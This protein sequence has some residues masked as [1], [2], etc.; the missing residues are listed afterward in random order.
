[1]IILPLSFACGFLFIQNIE[2]K[3]DVAYADETNITAPYIATINQVPRAVENLTYNGTAQALVTP[4]TSI[5]GVIKYSLDGGEWDS[6][7]PKATEAGTYVV[8]CKAVGDGMVYA[9][10]IEVSVEVSI[11][12]ATDNE[13]LYA[14]TNY[15]NGWTYGDTPSKPR[16]KVRY[17]ELV[18]EY[19]LMYGENAGVYSTEI[20]TNAGFY[21][22]RVSCP[23]TANYNGLDYRESS[24]FI[25][26]KIIDVPEIEVQDFMYDGS[27]KII[28]VPE[29]EYYYV[30]DD[31]NIISEAGE[32]SLV[33]RLT[34]RLN[35]K[36]N[37]SAGV[38]FNTLER[39]LHYDFSVAAK[40]PAAFV[41]LPTIDETL[42]YSGEEIPLLL[43]GGEATNG[44]AKYRLA[45]GEW[46]T[47]YSA[48]TAKNV[49]SYIV[50]YMVEADINSLEY[51]DSMIYSQ[52][53]VIS[54]VV[55]AKPILDEREFIF[56]G[57]EQ[58][59]NVDI[60]TGAELCEDSDMFTQ[61]NV[62]Y[63]LIK[64]KLCDTENY[65]WDDGTTDELA[66]NFVI[67][68]YEVTI[69]WTQDFVYNGETQ[70]VE[71]YYLDVEGSRV[72]LV[73]SVM[74]E[75][76]N[77]GDYQAT[78]SFANEET[79][80]I[81]PND[82]DTTITISKAMSQFGTQPRG[83]SAIYSD[84]MIDLVVAGTTD[85]GVM[86]YSIDNETWS[87]S[88]PQAS[89][90]GNY[91]V[92][93]KIVGDENHYDSEIIT[94]FSAISDMTFSVMPTAIVGLE[95]D[96]VSHLL[97]TPA[98][99]TET[100]SVVKYSIDGSNTWS[101]D[102]PTAMD[103]GKYYVLCAIFIDGTITTQLEV[104]VTI[105]KAEASVI[106]S[107]GEYYYTG[108]EQIINASFTDID[109]QIIS[110]DVFVDRPFIDAGEYL[111]RIHSNEITNYALLG[112]SKTVTILPVVAEFVVAPKAKNIRY[113]SD[114]VFDLIEK[115]E[116]ND[117]IVMYSLDGEVWSADVPTAS[118][119]GTY[120][121][122]VK[123]EPDSNHLAGEVVE[124]IT[125]IADVAF[126]VLPTAIDGLVYDG[127]AHTLITSAQCDA[128]YGEV[129]YSIDNGLNWTIYEPTAIDAGVY[130]VWVAIFNGEQK[131]LQVDVIATLSP[132]V[133]EIN[134]AKDDFTYNGTIQEI[135]IC[136]A[137][138][139]G[140]SIQLAT[141]ADSEFKDAGEYEITVDFKNGEINYCLPSTTSRVYTMKKAVAHFATLPASISAKY[142]AGETYE[143]VISGETQD[144]V[145]M[146]SL[147]GEEWSSEVPSSSIVGKYTVLAKVSG[148]NN[149]LDSEIIE[150]YSTIYNVTFSILPTAVENL[151]YNGNSQTL[152]TQAICSDDEFV[153]KYRLSMNEDWS[154]V[155]PT[156]INAGSYTVMCAA[157]NGDEVVEQEAVTVKIMPKVVTINW[158]ENN[159]VYNGNE[160]K[161]NANYT[162]VNG[163]KVDLSVRVNKV[164]KNVA[165]NYEA[166]VSFA[167]LTTNYTLP[168]VITRI[169]TIEPKE[170]EI[171]WSYN[172]YT[173][174]GEVQTIEANYLDVNQNLV[175]LSV[176][177]N[178]PFCVAGEYTATA[179]FKWAE[180][181]YCLPAEVTKQFNMKKYLVT[182]PNEDS[183]V[184]YYTGNSITYVI[185]ESAYYTVSGNVVQNVGRYNVVV[186]LTDKAN[187]AWSDQTS[188]NLI[189]RFEVIQTFR[190]MD[191]E[192]N[193][194]AVVAKYASV[195]SVSDNFKNVEPTVDVKEVIEI[196]NISEEAT[197]KVVMTKKA[198]WGENFELVLIEGNTMTLLPYTITTGENGEQVVN[199]E[200][201]KQGKLA[202][203]KTNQTA[204]EDN[205]SAKESNNAHVWIWIICFVVIAG[206]MI[207]A[208]LLYRRNQY[209]YNN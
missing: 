13:Y 68:P 70:N 133:V 122:L 39:D 121:V 204:Q 140:F 128:V 87:E 58:T 35:Y 205:A 56:N 138:I 23:A 106:W 148:D 183:T 191:K 33:I 49:G 134:W 77:A 154:E 43:T 42:V 90:K 28:E 41:T 20:P 27:T 65:I 168:N 82:T 14:Y 137:D 136:Y 161:I 24:F 157:V 202:V 32:Y 195:D 11:L 21:K 156:R 149:H 29:S 184:Y 194:E 50:E 38:V 198:E 16:I 147:D 180:T 112:D 64:I 124:L 125:T 118:E 86:V 66:F 10:S 129:R 30:V 207:L 169:Y 46:T 31:S 72:D 61:T 159:F 190:V 84:E 208:I 44:V 163:N 200:V 144:G 166:T 101:E 126:S 107:E 40:T 192:N 12:P 153:A 83:V 75:L 48:I 117:G 158:A 76:T 60:V 123:I 78:A 175:A 53:I 143:L 95:Y 164:F 110:L 165:S 146:Y 26:R 209:K 113:E 8:K 139:N 111:A 197:H 135:Y 3:A 71:A 206:G 88:I 115:A 45:G 69:V 167:L 170:I 79:N 74:G 131:L 176:T 4:A 119:M 181:N 34:D 81:L 102:I 178:A 114:Q 173:Y 201:S 196:S 98:V 105:A 17:G 150:L 89:E 171:I 162:D 182:K 25:S 185:A 104:E 155:L 73:V 36:W 52:E 55:V 172:N 141:I 67:N 37:T 22:V 7:I 174:N 94:V 145:V 63:Y 47:D 189:Y 188:E 80:Y 19:A 151:V 18:V 120:K 103:A 152:I 97:I 9:D 51:C 100:D 57:R 93:C 54:P 187:T 177:T 109:G 85:C 193:D 160:Q 127:I 62:G 99:S 116:S 179:D 108:S 142:E 1:M 91:E 132:K 2:S 15:I 203:I 6:T 5:N 130:E 186:T 199:F 96:G 92:Y 59:Y